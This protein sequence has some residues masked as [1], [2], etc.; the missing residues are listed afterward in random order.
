MDRCVVALSS[1]SNQDEALKEVLQQLE[2]HESKPILIILFSELSLLPYC[3]KKIK[4][5]YPD[6]TVIGSTTY[7]NFS[8]EGYSHGGLSVMAINSG[9]ECSCG[10]LFDANHY[11]SL[12]KEHIR[13]A[14]EKLSSTE[15]TCCLEFTT[16]F[17]N[18]EDLVLDTFHELLEGTGIS[19]F[20]GSSGA[21]V[22]EKQTLVALNGDVYV[23]TCA[24]VFI[25]NLNGKISFFKENIYKP[26]IHKFITTDIDC[27]EQ[28]V[29]EYNNQPAAD[30]LAE[31]LGTDL[32][33]LQQKLTEHPMGRIVNNEIYITESNEV[34]PDGAIS[35]FARIYNHTKMVLLEVDDFQKVWKETSERVAAEVEKPSFSIS[36]NCLSRSKLFEK[37]NCFS[38]FVNGL[39]KYGSFIGLSGYG[40][41]L[42]IIHLNQTMIL[43]VFE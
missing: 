42:D 33:G 34:K 2:F 25:H 22:D 5:R 7:V 14:L 20:G 1:N 12:Y 16:A 11:P 35:Y 17:G 21:A 31:T 13:L 19:L 37:E 32:D 36:I 4:E 27:D 15:N 23:N 43:A 38:E 18:G 24:F 28:L 10:L 6:S 29:Y 40:E 8:S 3:T 30:I 26:T 41:Q 9:I 39:R